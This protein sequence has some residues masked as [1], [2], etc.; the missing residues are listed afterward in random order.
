MTY[1]CNTYALLEC[2]NILP[3][4]VYIKPLEANYKIKIPYFSSI[5]SST[6]QM[7]ANIAPTTHT[8]AE[9]KL[10]NNDEWRKNP[11][12]ILGFNKINYI[13][14]NLLFDEYPLIKKI[15]FTKTKFKNRIFKL[16]DFQYFYKMNMVQNKEII[17]YFNNITPIFTNCRLNSVSALTQFNFYY[18][19]DK[20]WDN[21]VTLFQYTQ[22]HHF[23]EYYECK[24]WVDEI[25]YTIILSLLSPKLQTELQ[26]ITYI[27]N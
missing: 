13:M 5:F 1:Y 20:K 24:I 16:G 3:E 19:S 14:I 23:E 6:I 22:D 8:I 18:T 17:K 9:H 26:Q 10:I 2:L 11:E 15:L 4:N 25:Q 7:L 12:C 21:K 27:N